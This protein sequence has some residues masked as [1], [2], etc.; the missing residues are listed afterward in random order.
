LRGNDGLHGAKRVVTSYRVGSA[1][2]VPNR[3]PR[4]WVLEGS[5]DG[6]T[7][8]AVDTQTNQ[9]FSGRQM[10]KSYNSSSTTTYNRYRFRVT[11]NNGGAEF[12]MS[13]LQLLGY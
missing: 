4:S 7:W 13:E 3:D 10:L 5:N 2:D 8:T 9:S 1:N 6:T 11:A 12:Q